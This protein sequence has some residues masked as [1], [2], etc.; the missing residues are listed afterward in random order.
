MRRKGAGSGSPARSPAP[1]LH[2]LSL[3]YLAALLGSGVGRRHRGALALALVL[4][5]ARGV[6]AVLPAVALARIDPRTPDLSACFLVGSRRDAAG[7]DQ[8][9]SGAREQH[10]LTHRVPP[11]V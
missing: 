5:L 3:D 9:R 1:F 7:Q 6:G 2:L 8:S 10:S 11:L 4:P